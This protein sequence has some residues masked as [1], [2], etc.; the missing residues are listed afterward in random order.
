MKYF[1]VV[2]EASGDLHAANLMQ[3]IIEAD[4]EACFAYMGGAKM[5]A[6]GGHCV[7]ASEDLAVMGIRDVVKSYSKIRTAGKKVQEAL[8]HFQPNV[9]ICVDYSGFC[10]RYILPFVHHYLPQAKLVYY[11]PPK[12]WAWRS[13]RNRQLQRYCHL[14]GSIFPFEVDYFHKKGLP[15]ALYVGNP[16]YQQIEQFLQNPASQVRDDLPAHYIALLPGSRESEIRDNLPMMLRVAQDFPDYQIVIA[17]APTQPAALYEGI[18]AMASQKSNRPTPQLLQGET[19]RLTLH[20]DAALVTSGTATLETALLG[21]PQVVCYAVAGGPL[22]NLIF[23]HFFNAPYISLVNL[24]AGECVVPELF[25]KNFRQ[26]KIWTALAPLLGESEARERIRQGYDHV[27]A[28]LAEV[29]AL[30]L[31]QLL[32]NSTTATPL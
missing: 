26:D 9:V 8:L 16:T 21:T 14:I 27:R 3:E 17:Q 5:R 13:G 15:Q 20:A 19:L 4:P 23:D 12:V 18:I 2:G 10:F 7:Q 29:P 28:E 32:A 11:I 25:G 22:P 6:I 30:S 24:L 1:L 31:G